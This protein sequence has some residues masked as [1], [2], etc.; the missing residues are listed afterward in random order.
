[1]R[2]DLNSLLDSLDLAVGTAADMFGTDGLDEI[3]ELGRNAR[4]RVGFL[5]E[6]VVVALAGGTG[7]GKSSTLNALAGAEVT[8]TGVVRPTTDHPLAWIPS[9]P[10]PGLIRLLDELEIDDRVGHERF[11]HLAMIDLPDMD[12]YDEA[13]V[14]EVERLIPRIDAVLWVFDPLKYND[15]S[16][17][18]GFLQRLAPYESQFLFVLNHADRLPPTDQEAVVDDLWKTLTEDGIADPTIL[19]T[20]AAPD[21]GDPQG[22]DALEAALEERFEGKQAAV[23]K[24]VADVRAAADAL[25]EITGVQSTQSLRVEER[26]QHAKHSAA[27]ALA[28]RVVDQTVRA[29][30][31]QLGE[32][33]AVIA[34]S[35]PVA[36]MVAR[37]RGSTVARSLGLGDDGV[38]LPTPNDLV[39][40]G[41][42]LDAVKPVT[43][44][45]TDLSV[46]VGGRMGAKL[47]ET[48]APEILDTEIQDA[49]VAGQAAA[50]EPQEPGALGWWRWG[51]VAQTVLSAVVILA[52]LAAFFGIGGFESGS[53]PIALLVAALA[54]IVGLIV[55]GI[56]RGSGRAEGRRAADAHRTKVLGHIKDAME[57]RIGTP[58]KQDLRARGEL[59]AALASV[60]LEAQAFAERPRVWIRS[61]GVGSARSERRVTLRERP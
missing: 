30:M 24:L 18:K 13:N 57:R 40:G 22:I 10:E 25:A 47:R 26:W 45:T 8:R 49:V 19:V 54:I 14:A 5:G 4:R 33:T 27:E 51:A 9:N 37:M 36:R 58:L 6:T 3:A 60:Q 15:R 39:A 52:V 41:G 61:P 32:Q 7:S 35:G 21:W 55:S 44:L 46:D 20:A 50:G 38:S 43:D 29:D 28:D 2:P 34:G 31:E 17:H 11:A 53:W 59:A 48:Y 42:W 12:S 16:I 56:V 23:Q 1:M